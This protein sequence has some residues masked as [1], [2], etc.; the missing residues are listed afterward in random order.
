MASA[1][2]PKVAQGEVDEAS[3]DIE[4]DGIAPSAQPE[5]MREL[6][7]NVAPMSVSSRGAPPGASTTP[8]PRS[9]ILPVA[10]GSLTSPVSSPPVLAISPSVPS[11]RPASVIQS[12]V[13]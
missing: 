13:A 9:G 4:P 10:L 11:D 2:R 7:G 3:D 1:P 12:G 8:S 6:V 5:S